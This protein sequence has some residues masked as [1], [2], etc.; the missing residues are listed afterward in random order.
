M[1]W[2][3]DCDDIDVAV[4]LARASSRWNVCRVTRLTIAVGVLGA[5]IAILTSVRGAQV[6][7]STPSLAALPIADEPA[8]GEP[9]LPAPF[10]RMGYRHGRPHLIQ[11]VRLE[12]NAVEVEISTARAF[13]RMQA[14]A[15]EDGVGLG[16]ESGFRTAEQQR[17]LFRA[18]RRGHGNKAAR[19]GESNHQSG[20]ALD[21]A[22]RNRDGFAW[23]EANAAAFRFKRTVKGEPWHWEYVDA[24]IARDPTRRVAKLKKLMRPKHRKRTNAPEGVS[25][26]S[27][28]PS[29]GVPSHLVSRRHSVRISHGMLTATHEEVAKAS[30]DGDSDG[31]KDDARE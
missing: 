17:E 9:Q 12:P 16:I 18:W 19:P 7:A 23:L 28:R 25:F 5:F 20:R 31:E 21:I 14:A 30:S 6:E 24:P 11:V 2:P 15:A 13:L 22:F 3:A 29:N 8:Q 26:T 4:P 10:P 1:A 27:S